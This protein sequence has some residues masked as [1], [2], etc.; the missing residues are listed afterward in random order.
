MYKL[1]LIFTFVSFNAFSGIKHPLEACKKTTLIDS[2]EVD[3]RVK[4][5]LEIIHDQKNY[6]ACLFASL[7]SEL[8]YLV[9]RKYQESDEILTY[10]YLQ[11][12][13]KQCDH[14]TCRI[15]EI[16]QL[17]KDGNYFENSFSNI[18]KIEE[19]NF[20]EKKRGLCFNSVELLSDHDEPDL[21]FEPIQ[22]INF[23]F[24]NN[25]SVEKTI[26]EYPSLYASEMIPDVFERKCS[27]QYNEDSNQYLACLIT[28]RFPFIY[29]HMNDFKSIDCHQGEV[30]KLISSI[31]EVFDVKANFFDLLD[32]LVEIPLNCNSNLSKEKILENFESKKVKIVKINGKKKYINSE[33]F[34]E[35]NEECEKKYSLPEKI[36][37]CFEDAKEKICNDGVHCKTSWGFF[38][39]AL[40]HDMANA[41]RPVSLGFNMKIFEPIKDIITNDLEGKHAMLA[42]GVAECKEEKKKCLL[43]QNSWGKNGYSGNKKVWLPGYEKRGIYPY[44]IDENFGMDFSR[45]WICDENLL[46]DHLEQINYIKT[47]RPLI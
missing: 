44:E 43:V 37:K 9:R 33:K 16:D 29:T 46:N 36:N 23:Y 17:L 5:P 18:Q 35:A 32:S 10:E 11:Y 27:E 22:I 47:Y 12:L 8:N 19:K 28:R 40:A 38:E 2:P 7:S 39:N 24:K 3:K 14:K 30:S 41:R 42:V 4:E 45:F 13:S 20:K 26:K 15:E 34:T 1:F 31:E 25:K 6:G 21:Y